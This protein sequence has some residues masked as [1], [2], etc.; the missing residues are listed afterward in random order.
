MTTARF[1]KEHRGAKFYL[2]RGIWQW[3]GVVPPFLFRLRAWYARRVFLTSSFRNTS[4]AEL[5]QSNKVFSDPAMSFDIVTLATFLA[6]RL[7]ERSG[8]L[9]QHCGFLFTRQE[10]RVNK[11]RTINSL[12]FQLIVLVTGSGL[13]RWLLCVRLRLS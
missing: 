3:A 4:S 7:E 9:L 13:G 12:E 8:Q 11:S 2:L 10:P 6:C 1:S 5:L